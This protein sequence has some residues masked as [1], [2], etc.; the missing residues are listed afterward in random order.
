MRRLRRSSRRSPRSVVWK[1][2]SSERSVYLASRVLPRYLSRLSSSAW[3]LS[4][5]ESASESATLA[6]W[7]C[8]SLP[9]DSERHSRSASPECGA[10]LRANSCQPPGGRAGGKLRCHQGGA[11]SLQRY[12]VLARFVLGERT[13]L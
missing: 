2:S 1:R 7:L 13:Q 4:A 10:L 12:H 5:S 9:L 8:L 3:V 11:L 6:Y